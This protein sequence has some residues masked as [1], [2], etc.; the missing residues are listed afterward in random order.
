MLLFGWWLFLSI[1]FFAQQEFPGF[2]QF[3]TVSVPTEQSD[4]PWNQHGS[5]WQGPLEEHFPLQ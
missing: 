3:A 5:G 2:C 4:T 1:C